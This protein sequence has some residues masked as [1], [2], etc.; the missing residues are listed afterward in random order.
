MI[1]EIPDENSII[2]WKYNDKDEWKS[3]EISELI[4][5][6][7]LFRNSEQVKGDKVKNMSNEEAIKNIVAYI[8]FNIED[9]PEEV[10]KAFD[11]AITVLKE[12]PQGE[13]IDKGEDMMIRW[14]CSECGRNDNHIYNFCPNC[15]A[16][17]RQEEKNEVTN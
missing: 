11:V 3:S 2:K 6:Y 4:K 14:K 12:R 15:G 1:I 16:D 7:E 10:G 17:M 9:I 8:Y 13:W 5:A